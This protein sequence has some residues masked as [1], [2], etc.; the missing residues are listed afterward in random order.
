MFEIGV[1]LTILAIFLKIWPWLWERILY[2]KNERR[3]RKELRPLIDKAN[4]G[5]KAAQIAC[6]NNGLIN[7]G[8]ALCEDGINV[9]STYSLPTKWL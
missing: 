1:F 3:L 7:K 2:D 6:D 5:N 8:M 9:R 4:N